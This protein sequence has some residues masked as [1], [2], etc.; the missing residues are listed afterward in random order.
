[1]HPNILSCCAFN[2]A[3]AVHSLSGTVDP[4]A[5]CVDVMPTLFYHN[6]G[7][8]SRQMSNL[9]HFIPCRAWTMVD[10]Q[11]EPVVPLLFLVQFHVTSFPAGFHVTYPTINYDAGFLGAGSHYIQIVSF[12]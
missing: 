4:C 6:S 7:Q 12:I 11:F 3:V 1:M 9:L 8:R 5:I 2:R 10:S